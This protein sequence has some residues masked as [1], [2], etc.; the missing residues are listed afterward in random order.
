MGSDDNLGGVFRLIGQYRQLLL[1]GVPGMFSLLAG[2]AWGLW[3]V[4]VFLRKHALL[5]GSAMISVLLSIIGALALFTG[6]IL[7][8]VRG[9]L[10]DWA[11]HGKRRAHSSS[12][13]CQVLRFVRR[14]PLILFG[15]PGTILLL[16]G[17]GWGMRVVA[18]MRR[19]HGLAMG[20]ALICMLLSIVGSLGILAGIILQ[21]VRGMLLRNLGSTIHRQRNKS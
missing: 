7:H 13:W 12:G 5:V 4:D 20:S 17:V 18:I 8:A 19:T 11:Q 15:G 16:A 9:L 3:V 14:R 2:V 10:M 6:T 21:S 1:L